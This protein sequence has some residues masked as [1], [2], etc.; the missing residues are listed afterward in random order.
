MTSGQLY[1]AKVAAYNGFYL[2]PYA[3]TSIAVYP[4]STAPQS[5][6]GVYM[7]VLSDTAF[8]VW[9]NPPVQTGGAPIS[10]YSV[11]WDTDLSFGQNANSKFVT[12][13]TSFIITGLT[14]GSSY[15]VRVAAYNIRGYSP[16]TLATPS[17]GWAE[18][19]LIQINSTAVIS[20]ADTYKLQVSD[21]YRTATTGAISGIATASDVQNALQ[22]LDSVGTVIVSRADETY[23]FDTS[24]VG[25]DPTLFRYLVTFVKSGFVDNKPSLSV[26]SPSAALAGLITVSTLQD[27]VSQVSYFMK[28]TKTYPTAPENVTLTVV[29][30]TELGVLWNAPLYNGGNSVTKFLVEWDVSPYFIRSNKTA[31]EA[32]ISAGNAASVGAVAGV[33]SYGYQIRGLPALPIYVRVSAFNGIGY[34]FA[35]PAWPINSTSCNLMP[36]HCAATPAEQLLYLPVNPYVQLS[37]MQV[38]NRLEVSWAQPAYDVNGFVT[39]GHTPANLA[40]FYRVEWSNQNTFANSIF[41]D[42]RMLEGENSAVTCFDNCSYTIGVEVQ[43][44]TV[45][46]GNG[47]LLDGGSFQLYYV[48]KQGNFTMVQTRAN[49]VHV[50]IL[51]DIDLGVNDFLRIAG[52]V[53]QITQADGFGNVTLNHNFT[54]GFTRVVKAYYTKH[55][56]SCLSYNA[57][58]T[59]VDHYLESSINALYPLYSDK[60]QVTAE[61][62]IYGKSWLVTFTGQMFSDAVEDIV[63]VS[64]A[65]PAFHSPCASF[66][67]NGQI[68]TLAQ[69]TIKKRAIAGSVPVGV[70]NHVRVMAINDVGIGPSQVCTVSSDGYQGSIVPRS[71]PGLPINVTVTAVPTSNGDQLLIQWAE[72]ES[73][74]SAISKYSVEWSFDNAFAD[75]DNSAEILVPVE[76]PLTYS[77]VLTT[78]PGIAYAVRVRAFN[79][80]GAGGP[81]WFRLVGEHDTTPIV[82]ATDYHVGAQH[83]TPVCTVGISECSETQFSSILS[84]GVPGQS[85]LWVPN[86]PSV[87]NNCSFTKSSA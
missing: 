12:N 79:D 65:D 44:I 17:I 49:S 11:Q 50:S 34:S 58:A 14:V 5:P 43:N 15:A 63:V 37:Y 61:N 27:G 46:S 45:A 29:S 54:G 47:E 6:T 35:N 86:Y 28:A 87:G 57:L 66:T 7:S 30:N 38:A 41:Y 56:S 67:T 3:V 33:F 24:G 42:I 16:Y 60:F 10:G 68:T 62:H 4:H 70:A 52:R 59:D 32:V 74:G 71:P 22:A 23:S 81:A 8:L 64:S 83:A 75:F 40:T 39:S 76:K 31:Y 19:Q 72:G 77:Y 2:S 69:A 73:Y 82:T 20:S 85:P 25:T 36:T 48:G 1:V 53:Y 9:W 84:R 21:G 13:E 18:V 51:Q 26:S 80:Q 55:S 78:T